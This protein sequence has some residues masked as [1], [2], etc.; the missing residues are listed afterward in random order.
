MNREP[1]RQVILIAPQVIHG[2]T[3][4]SAAAG[5]IG[6]YL[7]YHGVP[8]RVVDENFTHE[9]PYPILQRHPPAVV[10]ISAESRNVDRALGIAEYAKAYG[11]LTVLG[12][13]HV[14]LVKEQ[15]LAWDAVDFAIHGDGEIAMHRFLSALAHRRPWNSVPGLMYR[16]NGG[17]SVIVNP[18]AHLPPLEELPFPDYTLAGIDRIDDYLLLTSRGCPYDCTF[19]TTGAVSSNR[20]R[21]RSITHAVQELEWARHRYGIRQFRIVD[22]NFSFD[23]D[24][25]KAFCALL[26]ER[27]LG[28][29]WEIMEGIRAD[30]VDEE[31]LD[32]MW[33]SGCRAVFFGIETV[34]NSLFDALRKGEKFEHIERAI[35]LARE[36]GFTVGGYFIV[37]LPGSS[38]ASEMKSV[39]FSQEKLDVASFWMAIP[40]YNTQLHQWVTERERLLREPK[41]ENLVNSLDTQ[42]FF[43]TEEF[44]AREVKRA[45][46]IANLR[47]RAYYRFEEIGGGQHARPFSW[48]WVRRQIDLVRRLLQARDVESWRIYLRTNTRVAYRFIRLLAGALRR[49][50]RQQYAT[51]LARL[52]EGEPNG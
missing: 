23:I 42:P 43:D 12:G 34:E 9:S 33:H 35:R 40:Y 24:R 14:S 44:P 21:A 49:Q 20:W 47:H 11:H 36:H 4:P 19:C 3:Y 28:L 7:S 50:N 51:R 38:F 25:V 27:K 6:A 45:H 17:G 31:L 37:G 30:K 16:E 2:H 41:G 32:L 46:L 29:R 48:P 8:V 26:I 18:Q 39:R 22:E 1:T 10:G 15:I 52:R 13:L 5:S